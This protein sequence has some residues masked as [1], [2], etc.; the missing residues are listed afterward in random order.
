[1]DEEGDSD[2][3]SASRQSTIRDNTCNSSITQKTTR[4]KVLAR[5]STHLADDVQYKVTTQTINS[6]QSTTQ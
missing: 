1:S 6:N 4:S 2:I 3:I 5:S